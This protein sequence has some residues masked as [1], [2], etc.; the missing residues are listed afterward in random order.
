MNIKKT[1]DA[2]VLAPQS[3]VSTESVVVPPKGQ[4]KKRLD[5]F[6]ASIKADPK[7]TNAKAWN[8]FH[9]YVKDLKNL[10]NE[11][12]LSNS[13][14]VINPGNAQWIPGTDEH[15]RPFIIGLRLGELISTTQTT[16]IK[17]T[18]TVK[19][20][21]DISEDYIL[22]TKKPIIDP[23]LKDEI[24]SQDKDPD[25]FLLSL[26]DDFFQ[27]PKLGWICIAND[28][29]EMATAETIYQIKRK[30]KRQRP[31]A[32]GTVID[33]PKHSSWPGG[34]GYRVGSLARFLYIALADKTTGPDQRELFR[35]RLSLGAWRIAMNREAAGLHWHNDTLVGLRLGA[36][37]VD[38]LIN[39][40]ASSATTQEDLLDVRALI[41]EIRR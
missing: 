25:V 19:N 13:I 3:R 6:R 40:V 41:A 9:T 21:D 37:L 5:D 27:A 2:K 12:T 26:L 20:S 39:S 16:N 30:V 22:D 18:I 31:N 4:S 38:R 11:W 7:S 14:P 32:T 15:A 1:L 17:A 34:H 28:V 35:Q 29:L 10:P 36:A 23:S 8:T 24:E 33:I